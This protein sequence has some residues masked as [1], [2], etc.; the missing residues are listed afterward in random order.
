MY[1]KYTFIR[2]AS[3]PPLTT[4]SKATALTTIHSAASEASTWTTEASTST[5]CEASTLTV[6][7]LAGRFAWL[8]L[9]RHTAR[10]SDVRGIHLPLVVVQYI[11]VQM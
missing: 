4:L 2:E 10:T 3:T 9:D 5:L 11:T 7:P 6:K 1:I 8:S